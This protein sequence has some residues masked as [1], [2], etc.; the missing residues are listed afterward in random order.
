MAISPILTIEIIEVMETYIS[1]IRPPVNIRP[2]LD[3]IYKIEKQSI[4]IYEV[5]PAWNN[6]DD[7]IER[8]IAKTT[9]VKKENHWKVFWQRSDL[10]WHTYPPSPVVKTIKAFIKLVENDKYACFWG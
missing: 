3:I 10:K 7:I 9:Y 5:R 8:P 4:V 6:P 1:K 2:E